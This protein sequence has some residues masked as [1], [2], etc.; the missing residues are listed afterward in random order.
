MGRRRAPETLDDIRTG[1]DVGAYVYAWANRNGATVSERHGKEPVYTVRWQDREGQHNA[2]ITGY[3]NHKSAE[4]L[5]P[6]QRSTMRRV[7]RL[8]GLVLALIIALQALG[9]DVFGL[10]CAACGVGAG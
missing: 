6:G 7:L 1:E 2:T 3:N 10:L 4:Q 8:A 9:V 5:T